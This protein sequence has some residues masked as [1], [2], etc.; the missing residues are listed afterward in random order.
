VL[1]HLAGTTGAVKNSTSS[2]AAKSK[3]AEVSKKSTDHPKYHGHQSI[4]K[5]IKS[6]YKVGE[7]TDSQV[8]LSIK[9][10]VTIHVF[11]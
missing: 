8:K 5:Y 6:K 2:P 11:K 9:R 10:L 1:H 4:Q 3:Q 7:N